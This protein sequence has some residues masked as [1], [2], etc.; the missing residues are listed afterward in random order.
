[1]LSVHTSTPFT[2]PKVKI[3]HSW[4]AAGRTGDLPELS[5]TMHERR[6]PAGKQDAVKIRV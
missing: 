4:N 5:K 2:V 6:L 1:M 3:T